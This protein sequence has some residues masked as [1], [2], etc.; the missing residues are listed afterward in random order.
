MAGKQSPST[1]TA[2]ELRRAA[3]SI[4][5]RLQAMANRER[6]RSAARA[7]EWGEIVGNDP[8]LLRAA[9]YMIDKYGEH[10]PLIGAK[11]AQHLI[12]AGQLQAAAIWIRVG[13][14][15]ARILTAQRN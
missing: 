14:T 1:P 3:R 15:A 9:R 10:A 5:D 8:D 7:F 11:R 2:S 4:I 12:G 13:I 6:H